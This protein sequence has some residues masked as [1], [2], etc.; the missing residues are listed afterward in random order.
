MKLTNAMTL[1]IFYAP[2]I[3]TDPVLPE[4]ESA[5]CTKVLRLGRGAELNV[6]DGRGAFYRAMI[7]E[8]HPR[9]CRV[10]VVERTVTPPL[11]PYGLHLRPYHRGEPRSCRLRSH[12]HLGRDRRVRHPVRSQQ[13]RTGPLNLP[14]RRRRTPGDHL[15]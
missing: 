14:I 13:Q 8:A 2:Q 10:T 12:L 5:H 3:D 15:Q 11:W 6:T 4:E 7:E 1:P 9:H